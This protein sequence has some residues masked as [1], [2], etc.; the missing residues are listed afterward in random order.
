[1][2]TSIR[3]ELDLAL[4]KPLLQDET[5]LDAAVPKGMPALKGGKAS[6]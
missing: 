1:M 6:K 2:G 5:A 4:R 3:A